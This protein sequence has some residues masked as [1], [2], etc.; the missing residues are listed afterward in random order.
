M[1]EKMLRRQEVEARVGIARSTIYQWVSEGRFPAPLKL[2]PRLIA[3]RE[4][5]LDR[6]LEARAT[7]C[8]ST[9]E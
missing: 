6:W 3:W 2:G 7:D 8:G 1:A 9:K 5:D 4:S